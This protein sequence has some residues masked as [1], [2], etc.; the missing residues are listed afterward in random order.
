MTLSLPSAIENLD[1]RWTKPWIGSFE[2]SDTECE[3]PLVNASYSRPELPRGC[4]NFTSSLR[5][6]MSVFLFPF[7]SLP[8]MHD[9]ITNCFTIVV[10][11]NEKSYQ[12]LVKS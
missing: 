4:V 8:D 1:Q 10:S 3:H 6:G 7:L 2:L 12:V 5:V 11:R 9:E